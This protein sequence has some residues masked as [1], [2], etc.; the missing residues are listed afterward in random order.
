MTKRKHPFIAKVNALIVEGNAKV[1]SKPRLVVTS[2]EEASFNVGGQIPTRKVTVTD[3]E[4]L[5]ETTFKDY[6]V[7]LVVTPEIKM[8]K[9]DMDLEIE[10]SSPDSSNSTTEDT[11][12]LSENLNTR[13][14]VNDQQ[15]VVIAGLIKKDRGEQV[16]RVAGLS[17][18][19]VLGAL[20]RNKSIQPNIDQE[21]IITITPTILEKNRGDIEEKVRTVSKVK[22]DVLFDSSLPVKT[23]PYYSGMPKEMNS[24]IQYV[25][26]M[27][28]AAVIFPNEAQE[29]GWEGT[30]KIGMMILRDGTLAY[31]LVQESSGFEVIDQQA[32]RIVKETAPYPNFPASSTQQEITVSIPIIFSLNN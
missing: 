5:L 21:I 23:E 2:G 8:G 11:A 27:I 19:P 12:Y 26:N 18:I 14:F 32:L 24:Y 29:Y 17:K 25:Q 28:S 7:S 13:I 3:E 16:N 9:I 4:T 6:G 30:V 10:I 15:T 22:K 1:L 20:F 31:A